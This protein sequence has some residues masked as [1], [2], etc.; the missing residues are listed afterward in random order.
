MSDKKFTVESGEERWDYDSDVP[1]REI[2]DY[3][4]RFGSE[5]VN[6]FA[7]RSDA[8]KYAKKLNNALNAVK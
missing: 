8:E 3:W 6:K 5:V 2:V 1:T 7:F 4:V